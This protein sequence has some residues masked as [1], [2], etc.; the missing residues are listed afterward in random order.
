MIYVD[1]QT[2]LYLTD[3]KWWSDEANEGCYCQEQCMDSLAKGEH[4]FY[5]QDTVRQPREGM[6]E[7]LSEWVSDWNRHDYYEQK[8]N[9]SKN[10]I[11]IFECCYFALVNEADKGKTLEKITLLSTS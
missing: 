6:D 4:D 5:C 1:H 8:Q 10:S 7:W 11:E 9:R 2:L 3:S